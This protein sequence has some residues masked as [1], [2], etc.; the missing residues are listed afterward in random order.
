MLKAFHLKI[1]I[2]LGDAMQ[3]TS[4]PENYYLRYARKLID[5]S[6]HPL[7][8]WNPFVVRQYPQDTPLDTLKLWEVFTSR[9]LI[10]PS[11]GLYN[12]NAEAWS[13]LYECPAVVRHPRLYI[14]GREETPFYPV[15][16]H[17]HGISHSTMP[18][19]VQRH[20]KA[21]YGREAVQV[22]LPDDPKI[23][24]IPYVETPTLMS[25]ARLLSRSELFI[26]MHSGPAWVAACYPWVKKKVIWN[27]FYDRARLEGRRPLDPMNL[28][29]MFDDL[30]LFEIY[31]QTDHDIGYTK[32]YHKI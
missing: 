24:G 16:I 18:D 11:S 7:F 3:F 6:N 25:L 1:N 15:V 20:V 32:T 31:N 14:E 21:L 23:E 10:V 8:D 12:C 9:R 30:T 26:G 4:L 19:H 5:A 22:G 29:S 2:G 27:P 13:T 17:A 28:D